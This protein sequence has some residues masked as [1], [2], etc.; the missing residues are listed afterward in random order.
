MNLPPRQS[1]VLDFIL[2]ELTGDEL[3]GSRPPTYSEIAEEFDVTRQTAAGH[4]DA[5]VAKGMLTKSPGHRGIDATKRA[6]TRAVVQEERR[7]GVRAGALAR[8]QPRALVVIKQLV[9]RMP[10][11]ERQLALE[12]AGG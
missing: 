5:L 4:V 6:W 2:Q 7:S 1:Q 9:R 10:E 8:R 12:F 3:T 11:A